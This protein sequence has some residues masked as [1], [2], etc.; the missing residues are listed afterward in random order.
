MLRISL[1]Q[2]GASMFHAEIEG[3]DNFIAEA[4]DTGRMALL[5]L[6]QDVAARLD[7]SI[8]THHEAPET[9]Q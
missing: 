1:E 3:L 7:S 8:V 2:V 6:F 4:G 9:V 5:R